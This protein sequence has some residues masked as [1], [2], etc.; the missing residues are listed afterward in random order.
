MRPHRNLELKSIPKSKHLNTIF[1]K[2]KLYGLELRLFILIIL[3]I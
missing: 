1:K 2:Y 3:N